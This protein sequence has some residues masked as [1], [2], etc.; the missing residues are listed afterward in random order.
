MAA[1]GGR[2]NRQHCRQDYRR[3]LIVAYLRKKNSCRP[4]FSKQAGRECHHASHTT[5]LQVW[6][7][8]QHPATAG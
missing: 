8:A 2:Q 7:Q 6:T 4:V 1:T 5:R 3:P